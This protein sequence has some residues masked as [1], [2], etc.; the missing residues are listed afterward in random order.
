MASAALRSAAGVALVAGGLFLVALGAERHGE[1]AA[2]ARPALPSTPPT[3]TPPTPST[4]ATTS[5]R[6]A[7]AATSSPVPSSSAVSPPA[8]SSAAAATSAAPAGSATAHAGPV[9]H[10]T[11]GG[12]VLPKDELARLIAAAAELRREPGKVTIEGFGDEAGTDEKAAGLGRRR[13]LLARQLLSDVGLDGERLVI[14][15]GDVAKDES[16]KG[17]VRV[18]PAGRA[19]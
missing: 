19:P 7:P 10:F 15:V 1:Q 8:A 17:T 14:S 6:P 9:F 16:L 2:A 12:I 4:P 11:P 5:A 3:P 13:A 18:S